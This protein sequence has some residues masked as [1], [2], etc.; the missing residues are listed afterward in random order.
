MNF[1][2]SIFLGLAVSFPLGILIPWA[3]CY[4]YTVITLVDRKKEVGRS[5]LKFR[6]ILLVLKFPHPNMI[7]SLH[8]HPPT[9][10]EKDLI[11]EQ[12]LL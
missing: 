11:L 7:A 2:H 6:V 4:K 9:L 12:I 10:S 1:I 5:L 3:H 8:Y